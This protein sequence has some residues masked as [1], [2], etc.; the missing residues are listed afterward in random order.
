M[1]RAIAVLLVSIATDPGRAAEDISLHALFEDKAILVIDGERRVLST[2]EASPEGVRLLATDTAAEEARIE[3]DGRRETVRLGVVTGSFEPAERPS[4]T[5]WAG[6]GGHFHA[7][8]AINGRPVRFLVDTGATLIALSGAD[9]QRLGIEYL[10]D[11]RPGYANTA[12]GVVRAYA[13]TLNRVGVG[14]ISLYNVPASV[15]EGSHPREILLGMSFLGR[16]DMRRE[17][18]K[19]ELIRR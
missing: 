18:M 14:P 10:R 8:G 5:L 3:V 16:L 19:L 12:G 11:G 4:V 7:D 13:V 15:V 2:G 17:G 6:T 9:A 1:K